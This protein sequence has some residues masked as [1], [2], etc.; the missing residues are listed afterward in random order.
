MLP[1]VMITFFSSVIAVGASFAAP[2]T[3]K[4]GIMFSPGVSG[5]EAIRRTMRAG[6]SFVAPGAYENI[7]VAWSQD[8]GFQQRIRQEGAWIVFDTRALGGCLFPNS[9]KLQGQ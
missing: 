8:T 6:G 5:E 4:I 3:G 1:A 9:A 2:S 7:L